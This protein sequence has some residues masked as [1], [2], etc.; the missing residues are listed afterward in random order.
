[1]TLRAVRG[2]MSRDRRGWMK[3]R[4]LEVVDKHGLISPCRAS[5][6]RRLPGICR[7]PMAQQVSMVG[8]G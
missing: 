7:S 5:P 6:V 8:P 3:V 4:D 1:V 2:V